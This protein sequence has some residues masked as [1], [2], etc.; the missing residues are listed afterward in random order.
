M[1]EDIGELDSAFKYL[2]EGNSK[3]KKLLKYSINQDK[4][5]FAILKSTQPKLF[6]N[7]LRV[8]EGSTKHLP[9]FILGMPRS[10][11]T[12]VE[13]IVSSHSKVTGAGELKYNRITALN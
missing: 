10:G 12:L 6:K 5:L 7:S 1:Y 2:S 13:Q 3:R 8:R 9:I 11:T 4:E